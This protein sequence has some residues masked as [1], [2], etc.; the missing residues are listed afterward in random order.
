[1]PT[2]LFA[3]EAFEEIWLHLLVGRSGERDEQLPSHNQFRK[4]KKQDVQTPI[5]QLAN[6]TTI[7][8][9]EN[10]SNETATSQEIGVIVRLAP[11][12]VVQEVMIAREPL[13]E[14]MAHVALEADRHGTTQ[15][16]QASL[17]VRALENRIT[18][19]LLPQI[20]TS[21][22]PKIT[23][24]SRHL[25]PQRRHP[26]KE[27][28]EETQPRLPR[29]T[30]PKTPL[31]PNAASVKTELVLNTEPVI[32]TEPKVENRQISPTGHHKVVFGGLVLRF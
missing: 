25:M 17:A 30:V 19:E 7:V 21:S 8:H 26:L 18:I 1:M 11:N 13:N 10:T 2:N 20:V 24:P 14:T 28:Q 12:S 5:A 31:G 4:L 23:L 3:E 22:L 15:E 29:A 32:K 9:R 16:H 27:H 6:L